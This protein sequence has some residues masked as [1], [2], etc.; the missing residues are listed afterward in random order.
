[1]CDAKGEAL[2]FGG[3]AYCSYFNGVVLGYSGGICLTLHK[4]LS[5]NKRT[6]IG[7]I[8]YRKHDKET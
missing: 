2:H 3:W 5:L 4:R 6:F 1:M 7:S 8:R